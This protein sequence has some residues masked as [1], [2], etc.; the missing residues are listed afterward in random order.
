MQ[1]AAET[2]GR[3]CR[4][5]QLHVPAAVLQVVRPVLQTFWRNVKGLTGVK[6]RWCCAGARTRAVVELWLANIILWRCCGVLRELRCSM[7]HSNLGNHGPVY[8][9]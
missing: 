1:S 5:T 6:T 3:D 4:A 9:G 8:Q 7:L 2:A